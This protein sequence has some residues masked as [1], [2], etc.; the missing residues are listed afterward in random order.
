MGKERLVQVFYSRRSFLHQV[1]GGSQILGTTQI[2]RATGCGVLGAAVPLGVEKGRAH[3][4]DDPPVADFFTAEKKNFRGVT[5]LDEKNELLSLEE[6]TFPRARPVVLHLWASWCA[7][8]LRE[9]AELD[10]L[11][12]AR[13]WPDEVMLVPATI[14]PSD[15]VAVIEDFYQ[16]A[17]VSLLPIYRVHPD[18][19]LLASLGL[20]TVPSTLLIDRSGVRRARADGPVPWHHADIIELMNRFDA[21]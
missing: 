12:H 5:L 3:S 17:T 4:P 19:E 15:S 1:L 18:S 10:F 9:L 7:P 11:L 6:K 21:L 13:S 14:E 20:S 2:L 16:R 8:C